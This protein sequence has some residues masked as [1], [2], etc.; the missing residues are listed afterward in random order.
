[1]CLL[2]ALPC[3]GM[4]A[5]CSAVWHVFEWLHVRMCAA[6]PCNPRAM[7][8]HGHAANMSQLRHGAFASSMPAHRA[9]TAAVQSTRWSPARPQLACHRNSDSL[10]AR[11]RPG[12]TACWGAAARSTF[13]PQGTSAASSPSRRPCSRR[14]VR[15]RDVDRARAGECRGGPAAARR[16]QGGGAI[17]MVRSS[18][19]AAA[20]AA[21]GDAAKQASTHC[22]ASPHTQR[23]IVGYCHST[24]AG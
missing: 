17:S 13:S 15:K 20:L 22:A 9:H 2:H 4:G 7:L 8:T 5:S 12:A 6:H 23:A 14:Q 24:C 11:R 10:A 21:G 19:R 16:A 3:V 18:Q 1:M